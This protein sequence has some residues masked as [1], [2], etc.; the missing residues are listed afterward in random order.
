VLDPSHGSGRTALAALELGRRYIGIELDESV[1][2]LALADFPALLSM[3]EVVH[4]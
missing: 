3:V 1:V 2:D 4:E